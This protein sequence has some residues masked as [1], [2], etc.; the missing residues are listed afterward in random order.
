MNKIDTLE[1]SESGPVVIVGNGP[2]IRNFDFSRLSGMK[3]FGMNRISRLY[4]EKH[5]I[6]D[7]FL[8]TTTNY[9]KDGW[10]SDIDL[11]LNKCAV[12]FV[13]DELNIEL[14]SGNI[15]EIK[16]H[17]GD[18]TFDDITNDTWSTDPKRGFSKFGTS[19]LV[20]IQLCV[21]LGFEEIYIIGA[22]LGFVEKPLFIRVLNK[23]GF[24]FGDKNHFFGGYGTPGFNANTLNRNMIR[25]HEI[26]LVNCSNV[27]IYNATQGGAL[28]V[29]PRKS[30]YA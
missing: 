6:P 25:A 10:K 7:F 5:W 1:N 20:A 15:Y 9:T 2:S 26:A 24:N 11:S 17:D 8:C 14:S 30:I 18:K 27:R 13:W 16:C 21:F 4:E 23:V 3:T 12:S 19:M 22:D 29:Y 28:E